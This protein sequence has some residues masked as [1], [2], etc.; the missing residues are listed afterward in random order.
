MDVVA[1]HRDLGAAAVRVTLQWKPGQAKL[2]DDAAH[3]R[4]RA[5]AAAKLGRAGRARRLR[6]RGLAAGDAE[7]RGRR[8]ARSSLGARG[9][10]EHP[11]RR[12]LERG[13]TRHSSGGRSR[14]PRRRTRRCSRPAT[15][16]STRSRK[17]VNVIGSLAPHEGPGA[18]IRDLGAAYRAS[19]RTAP[20]FDTFGT[21]PTRRSR[22]SRRSR[23]HRRRSRSTRATTWRLLQALTDAFGGTGQPVPGSGGTSPSGG[24]V[25]AAALGRVST[26]S[27]I[28]RRRSTPDGPVTIWYLEDGF[29]TVVPASRRGAYTGKESN[30]QLV[31]PL[32]Y[33]E[34]TQLVEPRPGRA[35]SA[36]RSSS[37]TAS[38]RSARSSTSSSPTSVSLRGW[39]SGLLWADGTQKPSY[40]IV[41][42]GDRGGGGRQVDCSRFA[43]RPRPACGVARPPWF[44][45]MRAPRGRLRR[46]LHARPARARPRAGGVRALGL[47]YGLELDPARY[48]EARAAAFAEVKRHPELDHDEEIWVLLHRADHRRD[49]RRRAT[50]TS[51]AVEME[52]RWVAVGALRALR[53]RAARRSTTFARAGS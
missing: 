1:A 42:A 12:D 49:G 28:R 27:G 17:N 37:P 35:S 44:T 7:A 14:A 19:G 51:A 3:L 48:D 9:R 15:T 16:P 38:P 45:S 30:R 20:I 31:Q 10:A 33:R 11:R 25:P 43:E 34:V 29:E 23:A 13:R 39:Q 50:P 52:R 22:A 41:K 36:T 32:V 18:F 46:R 47:R 53:R 5:Q 4:A 21:T 26:R 6:A 24:C 40:V 2:D 8:S